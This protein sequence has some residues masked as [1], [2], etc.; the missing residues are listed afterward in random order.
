MIILDVEQGSAAWIHARLGVVTGSATSNI[1][2][3]SNA[4]TVTV[5]DGDDVL[6]TYETISAAAKEHGVS[7]ATMTEAS[8]F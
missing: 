8:A 3:S 4:Y 7:P 5:S 1:V 6:R 2:T